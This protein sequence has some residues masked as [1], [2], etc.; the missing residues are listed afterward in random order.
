MPASTIVLHDHASANTTFTLVGATSKG[1]TY[2]D[3]TRSL[4]LPRSLDF[5]Y[6]IGVPGS[7]ANDKL[8]VVSRDTVINSNTGLVSTGSCKIEI[9][10]PRDSAWTANSTKDVMSFI[11]GLLSSA[12]WSGEIAEGMVPSEAT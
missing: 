10:V 5:Q 4:S 7:K 9:S 6:N 12:Q 2:R 8:V 1:A 11:S 3:S